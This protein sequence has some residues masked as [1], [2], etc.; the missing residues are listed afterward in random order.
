MK[1][2]KCGASINNGDSF[3]SKCGA[4]VPVQ[5]P[6]DNGNNNRLLIILI[7]ALT[8]VLVLIIAA[9]V[10]FLV[11][12]GS[13]KAKATPSPVPTPIPTAT[14]SPTAEPTP[15]PQIIYVTQPPA[16]HEAPPPQPYAPDNQPVQSGYRT[17][18]SSKYGFSCD[19]PA[20]FITYDDGTTSLY[21]VHSPDGAGYMK[22]NASSSSGQSV[23]SS[24]GNFISAHSG[25]I[26]YQS[27]GNDYYAVTIRS[28]GTE[29]YKYCKFKNGNMYW[30]EFTYPS[31]QHDIYDIYIN[32]VYSSIRYD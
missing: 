25:T 2:H 11:M 14:A 21:T 7:L 10:S 28:G 15:T 23:S 3:C 5:Q 22:I 30:F 19:Y 32:A 1:C 16:A 20:G 27:S 9:V 31:S 8:G 4:P 24:K 12:D 29:Y 17:Y 13:I 26:T 18:Y 6:Q